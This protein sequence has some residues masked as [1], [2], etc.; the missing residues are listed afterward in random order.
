MNKTTRTK[1]N[2]NKRSC[3]NVVIVLLGNLLFLVKTFEIW[4]NDATGE[5]HDV[6][7]HCIPS[8]CVKDFIAIVIIV[9]VLIC[10]DRVSD[11]SV[12]KR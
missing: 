11:F 7:R 5:L 3:V 10:I 6:I 9:I 12:N 4:H 1:Y 2:P 8:A